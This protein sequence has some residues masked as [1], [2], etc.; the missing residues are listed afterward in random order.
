MLILCN[1]ATQHINISLSLK[2]SGASTETTNGLVDCDTPLPNYVTVTRPNADGSHG[3]LFN[4]YHLDE[5]C[6]IMGDLH[7]KIV[8]R[9][10]VAVVICVYNE[11]WY[12]L[13][14]SLVSL[15]ATPDK[16]GNFDKTIIANSVAMDIAIVRRWH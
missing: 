10:T 8:H 4:S 5:H 7:E 1:H 15:A 2:N 3:K 12:S 11:E 13:K 16:S 9:A 14:R 6:K